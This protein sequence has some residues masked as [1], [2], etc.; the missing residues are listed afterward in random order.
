MTSAHPRDL[1]HLHGSKLDHLD[2]MDKFLERQNLP[3]PNHKEIENLNR[4]LTS[5][6]DESVIKNILTKKSPST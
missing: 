6:D 5:K 4:P 1:L 3:I 2:E